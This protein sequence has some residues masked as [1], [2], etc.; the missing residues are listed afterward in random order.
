MRR[1]G[2]AL[3]G[4]TLT[5]ASAARADEW[6]KTFSITGKPDLRVETSDAN[7]QVDTWDQNTIEAKVITDHD[8]IGENG[9]RV[10]DR[11]NGDSVEIEVRFPHHNFHV[12]F[13]MRHVN[14]Q[15]HMPREGKVAL[16]TG[17]GAIRVSHLKGEMDLRSG[18][19]S[20]EL[21]SLDGV[22]RA[23]TGDGHIRTTGRF[24]SLD[25]GTGDGRIEADALS[26]STTA[27]SWDLNTGD[28]SITLRVAE[29]FAA[30]VS[31]HTGDGHI[32]ME[33]PLTVEGQLDK[34]D[35]RGKLNGGGTHTV[36]IHT[37]DGSIRLEKLS[38]SI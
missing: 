4:L 38:S 10:I 9:I 32:T 12:E 8:K 33:M 22:L 25:L 6:S 15:I 34:K 26:G 18:D 16:R 13:G 31:L 7:I 28:G 20:Q 2:L 29:N 14:I 21:D 36:T 24:D 11:Q 1:I 19:G 35:V 17:D 3:L 37:G 27:S 23:H 5:F 30:D